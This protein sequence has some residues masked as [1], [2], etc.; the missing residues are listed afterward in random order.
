MKLTITSDA[1]I[2]GLTVN[3]EVIVSDADHAT[4][5]GFTVIVA[6]IPTEA[7]VSTE[8]DD[9]NDNPRHGI[10]SIEN[11]GPNYFTNAAPCLDEVPEEFYELDLTFENELK[12]PFDATDFEEDQLTFSFTSDAEDC[13]DCIAIETDS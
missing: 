2:A 5:Y 6:A 12:I 1:L 8:D 10:T 13:A 3:M 4:K 7:P 11:L 9:A